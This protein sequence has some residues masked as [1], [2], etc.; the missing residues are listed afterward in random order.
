[1]GDDRDRVWLHARAEVTIVELAEISGLEEA[2]L[3][4]LVDYGALAPVDPRVEPWLFCA[5]CV[6]RVRAAARLCK[7]LELE[8]SALALA[9]SFLGRIELLEGEVRALRA[10]LGQAARRP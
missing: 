5:D 7:D 10:Q 6:A 3:R 2:M 9:L 8:A 4:E 1:M